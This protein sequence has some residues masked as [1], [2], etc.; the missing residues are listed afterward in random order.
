MITL[1]A[2]S[3]SLRHPGLTAYLTA[4]RDHVIALSDLTLI[5]MRKS[6]A[7]STSRNSLQMA[8]RFTQQVYVL[9]RTDEILGD[10]V[11]SSTHAQ[12]LIDYEGTVEFARLCRDLQT[13]PEPPG[14]RAQMSEF[15]RNA[16]LVMS[17][18]SDEVAPLEAGLIDA[19]NEFNQGELTQI[20]TGNGVTD[21]TRRKLLDLLKETVGN[22]ILANQEPGKKGRMLLRDAL[23]MFAFRYSLCMLLYYMEWVRVGRTTGKKLPR[24]VNDVVDMQVAALATFFNGV[25][26]S[27][28]ALQT[29]SSRARGVLRGYGAH[30]GDDWSPPQPIPVA[31]APSH[32][33]SAD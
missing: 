31:G 12:R 18:L 24:R 26:S 21:A 19:A 6:N 27:D 25:L 29:I 28:A 9:R 33:P 17:R 15:E 13:I 23:G 22:F 10:N 32:E 11:I 20:R 14:L 8:S 30:V 16:Q 2:D 4:S 5:E 3:N 1:L 7:L